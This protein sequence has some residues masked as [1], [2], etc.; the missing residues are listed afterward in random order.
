MHTWSMFL[1]LETANFK[2]IKYLILREKNQ[3]WILSIY[4]IFHFGP[5]NPAGVCKLGHYFVTVVT[6]I[7][8]VD[9]N[10]L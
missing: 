8:E 5:I 2:N 6:R 9:L 1:A 4:I 10:H 7:G 3:F